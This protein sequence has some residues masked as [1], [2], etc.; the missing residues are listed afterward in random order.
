MEAIRLAGGWELF[1]QTVRR[2][3]TMQAARLTRIMSGI[4][5]PWDRRPEN[6][7]E[8]DFGTAGKNRSTRFSSSI[9]NRLILPPG[10]RQ[11]GALCWLRSGP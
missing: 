11:E 6:A 5:E 4:A 9:S 2:I 10:R 3:A 8:Y 1:A 7:L